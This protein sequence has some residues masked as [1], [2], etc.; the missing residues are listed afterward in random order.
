VEHLPNPE[1]I[2]MPT[3]RVECVAEPPRQSNK[4]NSRDVQWLHW[5]LSGPA[6]AF[7]GGA[8]PLLGGGNESLTSSSR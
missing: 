8:H 2:G 3:E 1:R 7:R 5:A 6:H 4:L